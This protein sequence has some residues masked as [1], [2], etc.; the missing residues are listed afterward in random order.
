MRLQFEA[1]DTDK[2]GNLTG[3][4]AV[5][6][7]RDAYVPPQHVV[8]AIMDRLDL[9]KN[10]QIT[11]DEFLQFM[12]NAMNALATDP[13]AKSVREMVAPFLATAASRGGSFRWQLCLREGER[14]RRA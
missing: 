8:D 13:N 3:D 11:L 9:D 12:S 6:L 4:E 7:A 14:H 1:L 2:D 5:A 10:R